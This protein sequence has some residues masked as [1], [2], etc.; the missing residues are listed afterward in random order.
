MKR[1]LILALFAICLSL[2]VINTSERSNAQKGSLGQRDS[3]DRDL[4]KTIRG[5]TNRSMEGLVEKRRPGKGGID[6]DLEGR[7]Q[8]VPLVKID[9]EGDPAVGCVATL[10]EANQFFG[11]D[12]ETGER[13]ANADDDAEYLATKRAAKNEMTAAEFAFYKDLAE[14]A[15]V[16]ASPNS[17]NIVIINGDGP[18]EGFNDLTPAT[19]EGG[20]A[21]V[22]LGQQRLN[23]FNHAAAIWGAFLDSTVPISVNAKF[24]PLTPCSSGGGVLGS[25]GAAGF[26]RDFAG[27]EFPS[28]Y[29]PVALRNKLVGSDGNVTVAEINAQFNSSVDTGCLGTGT[30][31]YYGLNNTTPSMRVNL[32][33]VLLHELGHGLG[34]LSV[35]NGTTGE[36]AGGLNDVFTK[37][38]FDK[39][40]NKYWSEM[41]NAERQASALNDGNLMFAGPNVRGASSLLTAGRDTS[42]GFVKLFAPTALQSG[43]SLSHFDKT[44]FPNLLMEPS[45]NAGLPLDLDLTRQE[46]RDIGWYRD[47]NGDRIPDS[48]TGVSAGGASLTAGDSTSVTWNNTTGFT[49][50]VIIEL[51]TDSGVTFPTVIASNVANTGSY[52]FTVPN[53]STTKARIRIREYDFSTPSGVSGSDFAIAPPSTT[54]TLS[55]QVLTPA[56]LGLRNAVV[57]M[58]DAAGARVTTV[59]SSLGFFNFQNVSNGSSVTLNVNSRRYRFDPRTVVASSSL[60]QISFVGME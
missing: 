45:I 5:L 39:S 42:T 49:Q 11:R 4:A 32:L 17:A 9:S 22:T 54:M 20:N 23:L 8:Q 46:M 10:D 38:M 55:G 3:K 35:A 53:V 48:I 50:N 33:V 7:F 34:F 37:Y 30:R 18:G 51:S 13:Y 24:D 58:T 1:P 16:V 47:A 6:L 57:S 21:G 2:L 60:G 44:A 15:N 28:T 52:S 59:T 41:T 19:P 26:S 31:F 36:M 27:A 12:L 43:S 29:Y 25:A 40:A 56:G 14:Q